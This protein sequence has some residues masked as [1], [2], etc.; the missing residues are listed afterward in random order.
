MIQEAVN[1]LEDLINNLDKSAEQISENSS[2]VNR[3]IQEIGS[4]S[5]QSAAN[6]EEVVA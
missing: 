5:E 4:V 2:M 6:A 1:S 3:S